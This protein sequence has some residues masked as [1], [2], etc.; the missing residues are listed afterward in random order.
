MQLGKAGK[1]N[2]V[3]VRLQEKAG[4]EPGTMPPMDEIKFS[5]RAKVWTVAIVA[6]VAILL[7]LRLGEALPPFIWAIVTAFVFNDLLTALTKRTGQPRWVWVTVVWLVFFGIV[8]LLS[9]TLVPTVSRQLGQFVKDIPGMRQQLDTYLADNATVDIAGIRFSSSSVKTVLDSVLAAAPETVNRLGPE[10]LR[11]SFHIALDTLVYFVATL[12]LMLMGSKPVFN[13]LNTLPLRYRG[14]M[15]NLV[16]RIDTVLGAYIKGQ[17]LLIAIMSVASFVVLEI[18]QVRYALALAIMVG[19]L[20]LVPFVG[21]YLAISVCSAVAFFQDT[22]AFGLPPLVVVGLVIVALFILRQLED[23]VVIPNIIGRIV[24]LPPLLVIFTVIAGAA[25]AGPMGLLLGIPV[26]AT[27]KIILGYLYY[28]LVDADRE[29]IL[30]PENA[31]FQ[32]LM[33]VLDGEPNRRLLIGVGDHPAYLEDPNNILIVQ[34][35]AVRK[36]LDL[37]FNCGDEKLAHSLRD[38]GFSIVELPQEHFAISNSR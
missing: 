4:L 6:V 11:G 23:L 30:L 37:A 16:L 21:P 36:H 2:R 33:K 8:A 24:E 34:K 28:K 18:L 3:T 26:V 32:D 14:E 15:R 35:T 29:K 22:H 19:V 12:Y 20:E 13:F 10:V 31:T 5:T 1:P 17:F 9:F 25:L 7:L 38:Y 27:L